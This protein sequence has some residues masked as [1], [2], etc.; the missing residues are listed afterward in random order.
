MMSG[1]RCTA[2]S[3]KANG[4]ATM[5]SQPRAASSQAEVALTV[6][7]ASTAAV[8]NSTTRSGGPMRLLQNRQRPPGG[9]HARPGPP[10][11]R[12]RRP[13][14]GQLRRRGSPRGAA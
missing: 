2:T 6:R 1:S 10:A 11:P 3:M 14:A 12:M 4:T 9:S 8:S 13:Q 7:T 5:A